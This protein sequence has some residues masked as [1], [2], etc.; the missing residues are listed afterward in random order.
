M[1]LYEVH[2]HRQTMCIILN[3]EARDDR[4]K[5]KQKMLVIVVAEVL[6]IDKQVIHV[7]ANVHTLLETSTVCKRARSVKR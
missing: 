7:A 4:G 6:I 2:K 5:R 3:P 1:H